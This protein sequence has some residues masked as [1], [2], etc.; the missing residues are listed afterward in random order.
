MFEQAVL[1]SS[2][3]GRRA[4]ATG[5]GI[6]IESLVIGTAVLIPMLWPQA[7]PRPQLLIAL[8]EPSAPLAP[9]HRPP[10]APH[11]QVVPRNTQPF[12][13]R[14]LQLPTRV[15]AHPIEIVDPPD[16]V[17]VVGMP[18]GVGT[19]QANG[20]GLGLVTAILD[21]ARVTPLPR[22]ETAAPA[23]RAVPPTPA[24]IKIGG[25]VQEARLLHR[26]Q[27]IYPTL[28][29]EMRIEGTVELTS[30]IGV[31]GRLKE[32]RV[33]SGHPLLVA[34]AVS[35]VSQWVYRPTYLNSEPVEVIAP[36][37][38]TFKLNR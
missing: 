5:L 2:T 32:L 16:Y 4:L 34:A 31:D 35:A 27:P 11:A 17:G 21:S 38:V 6:T 1:L 22:A 20:P 3:S 36:I 10:A 14:M 8:L 26:V 19:G 30:V 7:M 29:R 23:A 28:A 12:D 18:D 24:R 9:A 33:L 13:P 25:D 37:I 15:P